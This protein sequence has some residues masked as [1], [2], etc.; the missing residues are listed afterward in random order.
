MAQETP[1][2]RPQAVQMLSSSATTYGV[3]RN[4]SAGIRLP[5]QGLFRSLFSFKGPQ[6]CRTLILGGQSAEYPL[7]W[8][9]N[10]TDG[11]PQDSATKAKHDP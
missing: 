4:P 5:V 1:I 10:S 8:A 6:S 3:F 2:H 7:M 9:L 11:L